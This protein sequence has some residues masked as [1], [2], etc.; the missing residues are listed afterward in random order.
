M[1]ICRFTEMVFSSIEKYLVK[2]LSHLIGKI[3]HINCT[4][5]VSK[6]SLDLTALELEG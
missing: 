3:M 6:V 5:G 1:A 4:Q 2:T